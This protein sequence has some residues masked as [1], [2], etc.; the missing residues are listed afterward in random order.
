[1]PSAQRDLEEYAAVVAIDSQDRASKW[2]QE[3]W[4]KIFSLSDMPKRFSNVPESNALVGDVRDMLHYS[5]RI[6]YRVKESEQVVEILRVWHG[7]RRGLDE[8]DVD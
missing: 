1:M 2:L 6:V 8:I 5:H 3:A 4:E 7:A